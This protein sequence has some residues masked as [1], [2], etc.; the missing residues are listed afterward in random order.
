VW[1]YTDMNHT[2]IHACIHAYI[3][4]QVLEINR[5]T[6]GENHLDCAKVLVDIG[7]ALY[8]HEQYKKALPKFDDAFKSKLFACVCMCVCVC[9]CICI[10]VYGHRCRAIQT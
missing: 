1:R 8:R 7:V 6:L 10:C 2:Y 9:V 5:K 3:H 4:I